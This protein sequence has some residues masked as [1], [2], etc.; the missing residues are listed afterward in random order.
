MNN[1]NYYDFRK[2]QASWFISGIK[3]RVF[4]C[5]IYVA[6]VSTDFFIPNW[7]Y[8]SKNISLCPA[9][10]NV[11]EPLSIQGVP[12]MWEHLWTFVK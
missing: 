7:K 4:S 8:F 2:F 10:W 11:R 6:D 9:K 3:D 5:W 12:E 1:I